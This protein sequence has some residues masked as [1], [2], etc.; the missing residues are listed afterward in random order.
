MAGALFCSDCLQSLQSLQPES[1]FGAR[2][3]Q[4]QLGFCSWARP[5]MRL[6]ILLRVRFAGP[7]QAT[8]A[9]KGHMRNLAVC[10]CMHL[11]E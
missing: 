2:M 3:L 5:R 6:E 4:K 1:E 11:A 7:I 8:L 9:Q 10:K